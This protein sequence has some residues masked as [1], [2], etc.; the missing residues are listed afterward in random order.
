MRGR[1]P[2]RMLDREF[3]RTGKG[4]VGYFLPSAEDVARQHE[5]AVPRLIVF[6]RWRAGSPPLLTPLSQRDALVAMIRNSVN[7]DLLGE[8]GVR[9]MTHMV[10]RCPAYVFEYDDLDA[11]CACLAATVDQGPP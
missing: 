5:T 2:E 4:T 3:P 1:A 11:A 10:G 7:F 6:P 9:T 8:A